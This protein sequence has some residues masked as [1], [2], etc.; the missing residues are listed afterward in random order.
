M[1]FLLESIKQSK[2]YLYSA[3]SSIEDGEQHLQRIIELDRYWERLK[4][5]PQTVIW[6]SSDLPKDIVISGEYDLIYA[7][8]TLS[9][10]HAAMMVGKY[11]RKVMIFDRQTPA[12][13]TRDWNISRKELL[14]LS[15]IGLFTESEI[16]SAIVRQYKNGWVEFYQPDG[17]QKRLVMENV[18]DCA[19]D[20]DKLLCLAKEKIKSVPGNVIIAERT[21]IGCYQ[22]DDHI[23]VKIEDRQ[24]NAF[25]Y[26]AKVLVDVMGILS[27][28]AMQLNEGSPQ[29]HVCPTVG[30][31][32]SGFEDVDFDTGE[33]LVTTGPAEASS[34][35]G[36][37]L[38]WEGFPAE[39]SKYI[40]YLFFYD[41]ADSPNDKSLL[42]LFDTYFKTL[43][44]YKKQGVDFLVHR[45]V[46]GIIPAFF[47]DGFD[48]T[49]EIA[50]DHIIL[51]GDAASLGSPLTFC[52]FGS[53]VRNIHHLTGDLDRALSDNNLSKKHLEKIS[54]YEPNVASMANLMKYMCFNAATDEPNFVNDLMNEVMI[55]LDDLPHHYRQ[56]M[57]R[58]EMKIEE[59]VLV[60]LRV[61]WRYPKVLMA[62]WEKLGVQG[63][64]G[65]LKNLVGWA[66]SPV[67]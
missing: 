13:S 65:F 20:A 9:L 58:D 67:R 56:A 57:F 60:M 23:V 2:P 39:G 44:E 12:K 46:Y 29:T 26:K 45:P 33:I 25:Y 11:D 51:F 42:G 17:S 59:L 32:A 64:F 27:P 35:K 3:F 16:D 53:M 49:R 66:L 15:A 61:A 18:L 7:G 8:G 62:T 24:G 30:T 54:A 31:I 52:G 4:Q 14:N 34:G 63:S 36:R 40:S 50:D 48:R 5:P 37:Q 28:V 55:V 43:P 1:S 10:L 22:F 38:V 19:V 41:E 21:F 47:H 6:Q